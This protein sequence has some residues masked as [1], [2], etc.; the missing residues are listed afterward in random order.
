MKIICYGDSN[1]YGYDPVGRPALRYPAEAR[2]VD[3][4]AKHLQADGSTETGSAESGDAE[5]GRTE[6][7]SA[8]GMPEVSGVFNAGQN[9]REIPGNGWESAEG[10]AAQ[11]A[12]ATEPGGGAGLAVGPA[13]DLIIIMLGSNDVLLSSRTAE[14][15]AERM[16][17]FLGAVKMEAPGRQLL[18]VAPVGF[19]EGYWV[20][21]QRFI[22]ES[23]MLSELYRQLAE[24]K[25]GRA[26]V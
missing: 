16:K 9:G 4:L 14:K 10:V 23:E 3:I 18:L 12:A 26:H 19:K 7:G 13:G 11:L 1:T 15:T 8:A 22:E 20:P 2:W 5:L 21:E 6:S 17:R 25:I 24:E